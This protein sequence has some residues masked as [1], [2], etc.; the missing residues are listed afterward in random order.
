[1]SSESLFFLL[2][3]ATACERFA[4]LAVSRR[5]AAWSFARG[6]REYGGGH[7][8]LMVALHVAL[9]VGAPAEVFFFSR[10]FVPVVGWP[11]F[12][13]V[14]AAQALRWAAVATLGTHWT[15]RVIV[16]PGT[17]RIRSGPYRFMRHPNYLA[18]VVEGFALPLVHTAWI[19]AALFT[20]ANLPLLAVRI[21]CEER[22][23]LGKAAA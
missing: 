12:G 20:S 15:T 23:L 14:L 16:V 4:E 6:G 3:C 18:V 11:M 5:N 22:A 1:V 2:I 19:T 9:L 17:E 8:P 7:Y 13:L 10:P 21:R